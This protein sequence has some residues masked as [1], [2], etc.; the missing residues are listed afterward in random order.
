MDVIRGWVLLVR[1]IKEKRSKGLKGV[2]K[3][4]IEIMDHGIKRLPK[5]ENEHRFKM[6]LKIQIV[7]LM[8]D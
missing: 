6:Q 3:E 1:I 4:V 8:D 2:W 7:D 5:E